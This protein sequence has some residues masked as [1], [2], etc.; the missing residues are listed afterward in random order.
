MI[1]ASS[2]WRGMAMPCPRIVVMMSVN[3]TGPTTITPLRPRRLAANRF[4]VRSCADVS[5]DMGQTI[6]RIGWRGHVE[7]T[8][9]NV[10]I[11]LAIPGEAILARTRQTEENP[12]LNNRC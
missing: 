8:D 2:T 9:Q 10:A 6:P 1:D 11:A 4:A 5:S 3:D 12:W 7:Q